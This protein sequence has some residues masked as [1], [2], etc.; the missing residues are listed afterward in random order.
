MTLRFFKRIRLLPGLSLNLSK[1]GASLS[2]GGRGLRHTIGPRGSRTTLG[3]PGTGLS[4]SFTGKKPSSNAKPRAT[5]AQ[6]APV[7]KAAAERSAEGFLRAIIAFQAED[8]P[9]A[10]EHL[11]DVPSAADTDWLRGMIHLQMCDWALAKPAFEKAL[12]KPGD[13]GRLFAQEQISLAA[14]WP[15]TDEL[16]LSIAPEPVTTRLILAETCEELGLPHI[17]LK[18]LTRC[19]EEAPGDPA[20]A[21][22]LAEVALESGKGATL[23]SRVEQGLMDARQPGPLLWIVTLMLGRLRNRLGQHDAAIL[24]FMAGQQVQGLGPDSRHLLQYEMALTFAETGDRQRCRQ[25]LSV[26]YAHDPGFAD[27]AQRLGARPQPGPGTL[28]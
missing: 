9:H 25:E 1:S 7:T 21:V 11:N 4:Y 8:G 17:A 27:V 3:L 19:L 26:I 14:D 16:S 2:F 23:F 12:R 20:V 6:P 10:L 13:L 28:Q 5:R 15:L 18:H 24:E 22:A